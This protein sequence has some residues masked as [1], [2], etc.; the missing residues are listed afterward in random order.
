MLFDLPEQFQAVHARHVDVRQDRSQSRLNFP[1]EPFQRLDARAGE[2]HDVLALTDL[3]TKPLPKKVGDIG[4]IIRDQDAC[5]TRRLPGG[6]A[7]T[8]DAASANIVR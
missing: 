2:M 6:Q 1:R 8:H 4:L 3:T 7:D 5:A